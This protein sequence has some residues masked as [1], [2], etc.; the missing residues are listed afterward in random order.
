MMHSKNIIQLIVLS[1]FISVIVIYG[2]LFIFSNFVLQAQFLLVFLAVFGLFTLLLYIET[3]IS[4]T[5]KNFSKEEK[6]SL[7]PQ[8]PDVESRFSY[9]QLFT[10]SDEISHFIRIRLKSQEKLLEDY[11]KTTD[12]LNAHIIINQK[13]L[14]FSQLTIGADDE[15]SVHATIQKEI[16]SMI[17]SFNASSFYLT[18]DCSDL[19]RFDSSYGF[20]TDN[21]LLKSVPSADFSCPM[22]SEDLNVKV[23]EKIKYGNINHFISDVNRSEEVLDLLEIPI[24]IDKHLHGILHFY[25]TNPQQTLSKE[26]RLLL[27]EYPIQAVNTI[28][29]KILVKKT[30]FLSKYDSLT[31]LYNRSYFEQY[32]EDYNK[33]ALRYKEHYSIILIDLNKLKIIND[34]FGH[35]AGDKA[36]QTFATEF[37]NAIRETDILARF[38]GDEF[39]AIFHNSTFEQTEKRLKTI[40]ED[41]QNR[42][43]RYGGF[44][45]PIRF[46]YGISTSPNESMILNILVKIADERMYLLKEQLHEKEKNDFD[47]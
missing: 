13:F 38:G 20:D 31:G 39:I 8:Y 16:L 4:D 35:I 26:V 25:N 47:F 9:K 18:D 29:N 32:F 43:I 14:K 36:L 22:Y 27:K 41:F 10:F 5:L 12:E 11:N 28:T 15:K 37:K 3:N 44:N 42:H 45:I 7:L 34:K 1:I 30:F 46:S 24:Y 21:F 2:P 19:L 23:Y 33:H 40:H 6:Q 17:D